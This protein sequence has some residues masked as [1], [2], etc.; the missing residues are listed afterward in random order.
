M[1]VCPRRVLLRGLR[2]LRNSVANKTANGC[3]PPNERQRRLER[4][5]ADAG[6]PPPYSAT[7]KTPTT[8][9]F[10]FG[11]P[12]PPSGRAAVDTE[13]YPPRSAWRPATLPRAAALPAGG[14]AATPQARRLPRVALL[15]FNLTAVPGFHPSIPH[16][17]AP[18][19]PPAIS[20]CPAGPKQPRLCSAAQDEPATRP[21]PHFC[22]TVNRSTKSTGRLRQGVTG[23][24]TLGAETPWGFRAEC[25]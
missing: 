14:K 19:S 3:A 2:S 13:T 18:P 9:S 7:Q 16:I 8:H 4:L 20:D 10:V 24:E 12:T 25:T 15:A 1:G 21:L 11:A 22:R 23:P 5:T 6:T 17:L